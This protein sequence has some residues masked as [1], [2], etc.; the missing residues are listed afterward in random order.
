MICPAGFAAG[1][2]IAVQCVPACEAQV[3]R[4]PPQSLQRSLAARRPFFWKGHHPETL[5]VHD[6]AVNNKTQLGPAWP[7]VSPPVKAGFPERARAGTKPRATSSHAFVPGRCESFRTAGT[8]PSSH[9]MAIGPFDLLSRPGHFATD[10]PGRRVRLTAR[11]PPANSPCN[12]GQGA[13]LPWAH[14][15]EGRSQPDHGAGW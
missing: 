10:R 11:T 4:W 2:E 8:P 15:W 6:I 14:K 9:K 13:A 12:T 5:H 3:T 1:A 7:T